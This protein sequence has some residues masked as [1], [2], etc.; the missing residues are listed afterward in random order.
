MKTAKFIFRTGIIVTIVFLLSSYK[1]IIIKSLGSENVKNAPEFPE[2]ILKIVVNSCYDCHTSESK[3][4]VA[5][6]MLDFNKWNEYKTSKKIQLLSKMDE[7]IKEKTMPP[8]KYS[9]QNPDKILTQDQIDL[10]SK[11]ATEESD[12]LMGDS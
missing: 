10:F 6:T 4:Q 1:Y 8:K 9:D 11:W 12:K 5:K 3:S 2:E 7:E